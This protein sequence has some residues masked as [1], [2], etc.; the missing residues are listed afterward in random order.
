[1]TIRAGG[2]CAKI[3]FSAFPLGSALEPARCVREGAG[4]WA[5]PDRLHSPGCPVSWLPLGAVVGDWNPRK[6]EAGTAPPAAA[7]SAGSELPAPARQARGG[8]GIN[9]V[10]PAPG[11]QSHCLLPWS[12]PN[13]WLWLSALANL[14]ATSLSPLS[15]QLFHH[16]TNQFLL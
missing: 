14:W 13:G 3:H 10:S 4:R 1:M 6:G 9:Q 8:S 12:L 5:N 2:G 7:P 16:P 15:S 11:L